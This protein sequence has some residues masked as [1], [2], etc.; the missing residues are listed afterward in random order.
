[1]KRWFQWLIIRPWP[2][3]SL[4]LVSVVVAIGGNWTMDGNGPGFNKVAGALLQAVGAALVLI[5]L[6]GNVGLF[7][8]RGIIAEAL[9]W[10]HDY[11]KP[12]QTIELSAAASIQSNC[13][14]SG[15]ITCR[16]ST[17]DGRVAELER[18]VV[19][20]TTLITKSH[21]ELT[22]S[23]ATARLDARIAN[24]QIAFTIRDLEKKVVVSAVGGLKTQAFG[25]GLALLGSVLSVF[26]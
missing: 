1:M 13:T 7:K 11:P 3:W 26:S 2:I 19:E 4:L 17:I 15:A 8:G 6:D 21:S 22:E 20:L 9:K 5:S 24:S 23:I 14:T 18:V 12:P 10:V 25:V 16:P